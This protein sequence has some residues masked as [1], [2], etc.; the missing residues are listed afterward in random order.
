M[1][2][3]ANIT[4]TKKRRRVIVVSCLVALLSLAVLVYRSGAVVCTPLGAMTPILQLCQPASGETGWTAAINNNWQILDNLFNSNGTLK[5]QFG[6][7]GSTTGF[8]PSGAILMFDSGTCPVGFAEVTALRGRYPRGMLAAG[9]TIGTL[10]GT[11]LTA[12][13]NRPAGAHVH[14]M[15][16]RG[17]IGDALV[18]GSGDSA[19]PAITGTTDNGGLISGTP[20]PY[21]IVMFCKKT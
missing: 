13:E 1:A 8:I 7:T 3:S 17:P 16:F 11:A 6:G 14:S 2:P 15:T 10:V 9:E 20:A 18:P 4:H 21:E 19:A 12:N 5:T